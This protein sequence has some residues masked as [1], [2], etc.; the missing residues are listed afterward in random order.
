MIKKN[1]VKIS[2]ENHLKSHLPD[3][4][5]HPSGL[6]RKMSPDYIFD[7]ERVTFLLHNHLILVNLHYFSFLAI[8]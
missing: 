3:H 8:I 2:V 5:R 4:E 1:S 7:I 6:D